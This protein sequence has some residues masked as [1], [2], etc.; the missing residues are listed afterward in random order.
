[1]QVEVYVHVK[2]SEN[3]HLEVYEYRLKRPDL[4]LEVVYVKAGFSG[5]L[6]FF[7]FMDLLIG[8]HYG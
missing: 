2:E 1:M 5:I 3:S 8:E 4:K 7:R 6:F